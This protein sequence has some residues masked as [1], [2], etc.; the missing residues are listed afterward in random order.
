[1]SIQPTAHA[2]GYKPSPLR[3]WEKADQ[4]SVT[5]DRALAG[6][7]PVA[8]TYVGNPSFEPRQSTRKPQTVQPHP[9]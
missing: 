4:L 1:M 7:P 2:V 9:A 3:D 6:K 5:T 8:P